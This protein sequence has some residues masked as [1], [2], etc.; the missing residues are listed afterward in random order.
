MGDPIHQ[1]CFRLESY[2]TLQVFDA[3]VG[4]DNVPWLHRQKF[5]FRHLTQRFFD[6]L[7]E[8]HSFDGGVVTDVVN[9]KRRVT[10]GWVGSVGIEVGVWMCN[11]VK[12]AQCAIGNVINVGE[13]ALHLTVVEYVNGSAFHDGAG[14]QPR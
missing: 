1:L 11:A 9:L 3:S 6:R 8:C 5:L 14:K 12:Y 2:I 7:N 10:T 4:C 13:V